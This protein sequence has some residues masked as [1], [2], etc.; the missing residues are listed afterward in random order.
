MLAVGMRRPNRLHKTG[1]VPPL[2]REKD[3]GLEVIFPNVTT[4]RL[5]KQLIN[6]FILFCKLSN[7]M[8]EVALF[9]RTVQFPR[10]WSVELPAINWLEVQRV[11]NFQKKLNQWR[12]ELD[13]AAVD[14]VNRR[15]KQARTPLLY[16]LRIMS[17]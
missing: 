3:F 5:K 17:E 6:F 13:H 14:R 7:I 2:P 9:Q 4:L 11:E 8:E 12:S 10:D 15:S 1:Y 16:I